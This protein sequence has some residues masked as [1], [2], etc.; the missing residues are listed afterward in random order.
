MGKTKVKE[1]K[2]PL[3]LSKVVVYILLILLAITI[4]IPVGW[5]FVA[6]V[7]QN[8]E[9]YGSP[10]VLPE[11]IYFQNS[12]AEANEVMIKLA[13]KYGKDNFG[14]NR[15]HI[16][17]AKNSFHGRTL[18]TLAA[19]GQPGTAIQRNYDPMIPGFSSGTYFLWQACSLT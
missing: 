7:K 13:R 17:T 16:V 4:I 8:S 9:F 3:T 15:Y 18:A 2:K 19:T 11:K 12:G 14:P 6:S 10:W 1:S 5:V